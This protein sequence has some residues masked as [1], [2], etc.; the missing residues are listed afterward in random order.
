M[1]QPITRAGALAAGAALLASSAAAQQFSQLTGA[2]PGPNR[3]SEGVTAADVDLDGDLDLFFANGDGF[4]SPGTKRQN[5]L[6]IN[7]LVEQGPNIY[8]DESVARLGIRAS[9]AKLPVV[10]DVNGD[11]YPDVLFVNA[12]NTDVPF[13]YINRGAA[14]PGY[15]D[16]ESA[17]R[18]LTEVLSSAGAQFGDVD[19][20][21]DLDLV[22]TDSGNSLLGGSGARPKLCLNDGAGFFTDVSAQLN[23][24]IKVAQQD[25]AL[26]DIDNDWD[27]D[28]FLTN[29]AGNSNGTHYL[30]LNDGTGNFVDQS[31]LIPQTSS[32]VYE[33]E[34][35]DLDGDLDDDIFFLGLSGFQEGHVRGTLT[36]TG[37]L[38]FATGALEPGNVDD[39]EVALFDY[40]VDGDYESQL[41]V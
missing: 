15:F 1:T 9:H 16:M 26:V 37:T 38:G 3:W 14:Q 32:T 8:A 22:I 28:I 6:I 17:T 33:A 27:L 36:D 10:G 21:G 30:L 35:G 40:D 25:V 18:G 5:T 2:L 19:S 11:G 24:P 41:H 12:F 23:A 29:R 7:R 34:V 4:A 39:N 31:N 13:L 20:D